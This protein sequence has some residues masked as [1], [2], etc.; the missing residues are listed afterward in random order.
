M[1]K[2][3]DA[4]EY[5]VVTNDYSY[6][7]FNGGPY[8]A[9]VDSDTKKGG[10][11]GPG[12]SPAVKPMPPPRKENDGQT[13]AAVKTSALVESAHYRLLGPEYSDPNSSGE[14][15]DVI[16]ETYFTEVR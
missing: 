2:P 8:Y 16:Y 6:P 5:S 13:S 10:A 14:G 7:T 9:P 4:M 15:G 11:T 1:K 3:L 12:K